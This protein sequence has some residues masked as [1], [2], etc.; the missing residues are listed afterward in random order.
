MHVP[1]IL[2]R[3]AKRLVHTMPPGL[4]R[5]RPFSVFEIR[6]PNAA[7]F[8]R[9]DAAANVVIRWMENKSEADLLQNLANRENL[10]LW[11]GTTRHAATAWQGDQPVGIAWIARETFEEPELGLR[12]RLR[13]DEVWLFAAV[14]VP[15]LRRRGI[16]RNLLQFMCEEIASEG[17]RRIL[18][19][20]AAGNDPS[21]NA[22]LQ[23]GAEPV[24]RLLAVKCLGFSYCKAWGAIQRISASGWS[25]GGS[26]SLD[27]GRDLAVDNRTAESTHTKPECGRDE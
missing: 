5:L 3:V 21:R 15:E 18:L 24:G 13:H 10:A 1:P 2:Y 11:N 9:D 17:A 14:V 20:V 27:C 22:H 26:I 12:F 7:H 19:G 25:R 16:Y 23:Q 4:L 6:L 8:S